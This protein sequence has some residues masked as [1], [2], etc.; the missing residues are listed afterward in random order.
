MMRPILC[1]TS[2]VLAQIV[3]SH[4]ASAV[5]PAD[6]YPS[7]YVRLVIPTAPGG[8]VDMLGRIL[9]QKMSA[10]LQ[11]QFV[12]ENR[13]GASATIGTAFVARS[14]PDGYTLLFVP[15]SFTITPSL[16]KRLPFDP[17]KDLAPVMLVNS[18][19][20]VFVV[21]PSVPAGS[22][23]DLIK[24][25]KARPDLINYASAGVGTH[26]HLGMEM[27]KKMARIEAIHI[28][29]KGIG[30]AVYDILGGHSSLLIAGLPPIFSHIK[31]GK[32]RPIAVAE[33]ERSKLLPNLRT[34]AESGFRGY[35][36]D[37]WYGL[38]VSAGTPDAIIAKLNSELVR[39]LQTPQLREQLGEQ[40][41]EL[42]ASTP[43]RLA[44]QVKSEIPKWTKII[45]EIGLQPE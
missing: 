34:V 30:P 21:H 23:G 25:A 39:I 32:L 24:L 37:N 19:P 38:F 11:Q 2:A 26:S 18:A 12:L 8:G 5:S 22:V 44:E 31:A 9:A 27:F 42:I 10:T 4:T 41:F 36:V 13:P 45:R 29:H 14:A 7:K 28:P 40:G 17:I 33:A 35:A 3:V 43:E 15:S 1:L 16:Y 20:S 6:S